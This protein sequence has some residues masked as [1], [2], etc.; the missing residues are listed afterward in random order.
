[1]LQLRST[2]SFGKFVAHCQNRFS[3]GVSSIVETPTL[4]IEQE[5]N[6]RGPIAFG[7][8]SQ[9]LEKLCSI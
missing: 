8:R 9:Q 1:M 4:R 6:R 2:L 7:K 5:L 3:I